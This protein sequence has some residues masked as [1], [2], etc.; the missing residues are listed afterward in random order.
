MIELMIVFLTVGILTIGGGLVAIPLIKNEVVLRGLITTEEFILMIG[1]A[2]STPGPI[3]INVATFVG[4]SQFG[5][6]GA[7]ITTLS[8]VLPSFIILS[9]LYNVLMKYRHTLLVNTWLVYLKA[10]VTG[11]ILYAVLSLLETTIFEHEIAF[12]IESVVMVVIIIL[13][14]SKVH[15]KPW[16]L[17]VSGAL[18][19]LLSYFVSF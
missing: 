14:G 6:V 3:G 17:V 9:L 18:L 15:K 7:A 5:I 2:E 13:I 11:L 12:G 16:L 8:F 19:G 4:F 1:V 10:V